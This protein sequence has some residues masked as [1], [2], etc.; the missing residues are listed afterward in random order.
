MPIINK[1][2][3]SNKKAQVGF[4]VPAEYRERFLKLKQEIHDLSG[5]TMKYDISTDLVAAYEQ[6]LKNAEKQINKLK[7]IK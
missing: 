1:Q 5:G 6:S 3:D 4:Y 7:K 2:T